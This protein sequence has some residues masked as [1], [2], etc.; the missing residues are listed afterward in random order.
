MSSFGL[1]AIGYGL[2]MAGLAFAAYLFSAAQQQ[3]MIGGLLLLS[4]GVMK[5]ASKT[6]VK[7]AP[8]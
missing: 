6:K 3:N 8:N 4:L 1:S 2:R 5:A 7:D